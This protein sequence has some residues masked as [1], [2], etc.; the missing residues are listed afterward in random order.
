MRAEA[1]A[2]GESDAGEKAALNQ[3]HSQQICLKRC[4]ARPRNTLP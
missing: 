4:V 3:W 2:V 1:V